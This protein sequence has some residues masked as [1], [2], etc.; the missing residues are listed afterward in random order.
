MLSLWDHSNTVVSE[1]TNNICPGPKG[2]LLLLVEALSRCLQIKPFLSINQWF[3]TYKP[4]IQFHSF[5]FS[6]TNCSC[7]AVKSAYSKVTALR[8]GQQSISVMMP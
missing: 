2:K 6:C 4:K 8:Q 5:M 3:D 7:M 1:A